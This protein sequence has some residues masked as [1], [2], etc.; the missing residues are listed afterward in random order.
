MAG[1]IGFAPRSAASSRAAIDPTVP[2][3]NEP[4]MNTL[5]PPQANLSL[6]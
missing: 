1:H 6:P 2:H 3:Q 5:L 4:V